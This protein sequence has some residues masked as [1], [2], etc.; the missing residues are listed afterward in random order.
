MA[1]VHSLRTAN[2]VN[3]STIGKNILRMKDFHLQMIFSAVLSAGLTNWNPDVLGSP[4][5]LYNQAHEIV[6]IQSF[7]VVATAY[8]YTHMG[9]DLSRLQNIILIQELYKSFVYSHMANLTRMDLK[10]PGSV[11]RGNAATNAYRR[12]LAVRYQIHLFLSS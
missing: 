7:Q 4:D 6:A 10:N 8:G 11:S 2:Q 9:I 12:R 3:T 5:S 1:K